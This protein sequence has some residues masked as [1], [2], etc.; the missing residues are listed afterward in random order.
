MDVI[1]EKIAPAR[2][3]DGSLDMAYLLDNC[4][5]LS[6]F[7]DEVLRL[8]ADTIGT[9]LITGEATVGGKVL[10]PGRKLYTSLQQSFQGNESVLGAIGWFSGLRLLRIS[11]VKLLSLTVTQA[12]GTQPP[13]ILNQQ[14]DGIGQFTQ[15]DW[16]RDTGHD[17]GSPYYLQSANWLVLLFPFPFLLSIPNPSF[18]SSRNNGLRRFLGPHLPT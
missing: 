5:L 1:K 9:R 11:E 15:V 16:T 4:L 7:H 10:H 17:T 8:S 2:Q 12:L 3:P 6:S 14:C 13:C 18:I